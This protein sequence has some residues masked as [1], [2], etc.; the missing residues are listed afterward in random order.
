[1]SRQLGLIVA[2]LGS[3]GSG[4]SSIARVLKNKP[5]G[6]FTNVDLF[7]LFPFCMVDETS[8]AAAAT[9]PQGLPPRSYPGCVAKL[10]YFLFIYVSGYWLRIR[11]RSR[12]GALVIFDRYYH[13]LIVDPL[14]YRFRDP[15][16]LAHWIGKLV[17]KPDLWILLDAPAEVLQARKQEVPF[18]ETIRQ[19]EAYLKL[20]KGMKNGVVVD[21]SRDLE[22]VVTDVNAA[23][24]GFMAERTR[25]RRGF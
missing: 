15:V 22:D 9:N 19:R 13:D 2:I 24:L 4:K 12:D 25:K 16:A 21:A 10:L 20:V 18:E 5:P 17:P 23:I 7:H 6:H 3:D 8:P 11:P 1:M 14:R